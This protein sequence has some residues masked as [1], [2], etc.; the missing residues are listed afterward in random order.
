MYDLSEIDYA[1]FLCGLN[2]KVYSA[3]T[4]QAIGGIAAYNLNLASLTAAN[5]LGTQTLTRTV[6]N[7]GASSAVYNVSASLP[8]YTVAVTPT[9]L[10]L[11]PGDRHG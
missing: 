4:C 7:V 10:S 1:R 8:G 5:V 6:T 2:L 3:A 9:S 11:A